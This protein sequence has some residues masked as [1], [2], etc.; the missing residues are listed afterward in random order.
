[1]KALQDLVVFNMMVGYGNYRM[2]H[3]EINRENFP[4]PEPLPLHSS[5]KPYSFPDWI[6]TED[7]LK[8]MDN[9]GYRPATLYDLLVFGAKNPQEPKGF[10]DIVALGSVIDGVSRLPVCPEISRDFGRNLWLGEACGP[11]YKHSQFLAVR[12]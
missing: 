1:M 4:I 9:D 8:L 7:V 2:V 5:Y 10:V 11:W 12:E 6:K 3:G